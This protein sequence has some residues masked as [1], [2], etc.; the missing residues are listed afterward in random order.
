M[1]VRPKKLATRELVGKGDPQSPLDGGALLAAAQG[2]L[3]VLDADLLGRA[4]GSGAVRRALEA[5]HRAE[6]ERKRTGE[7]FEV[8]LRSFVGQVGAAWLLSCVFVRTLEDRGL[9][10]QARIA[11]PGALDSERQFFELAPSLTARDYL[12]AVFS[13]LGRFPAV[14]ELFDVRHNPVWLLAPSAEATRALLELFRA[15]HADGPAFRFGQDDTRFLGDLY[16]DLDEE[17]RSRFALLQTPR[18]VEAFI[19]DRTLEPAIERFGLDETTVID[20]TCGSGHFLLGAFERLLAH[21]LAREP[22]LDVREAARR[23]LEAVYGADINPYAVAI[24]R[25]RLT[26]AFLEKAGF[27]KLGQAPGL[28]LN[29]AVAD[30]L[31]HNWQREQRDLAD[32]AEAGAGWRDH[33]L[34]RLDDPAATKAV[35]GRT[36]AAVVGNPPYITPK[37]STLR[38]EYRRMYAE[39]AAGKYSLAAPFMQRFFQLGRPSASVG[40]IT[41]NSFMKREFGK[42]LIEGYLRMQN[43]DL[44]VNTSGAYIPGHGTP[45]VLVFGTSEAPKGREVQVV[46]ASR[47]EPETPEDAAEG[48]VWS[49]IRDHFA[50]VGFE[51]EYISVARVE[52]SSLEKH[53]WSL[54][55]GGAAELKELLEERAEKRLGD[56]AAEM[57]FA[58]FTGLDDIFI[59]PSHVARTRRFE[60]VVVRPMVV[61][62]S[63][64]DWSISTDEIAVTPYDKASHEPLALNPNAHWARFLWPFRTTA[65]NVASFGGKTREQEGQNWWEWYRWQAERYRAEFLLSFGEVATHN[66]FVLDRGGK[67]FNRTAP[68]IKLPEGATEEEHLALLAY[69]NSS[70]ACFWLKQACMNKGGSGIG[71]GIQD[72]AWEARF[73]FNTTKLAELPL[74]PG[75]TEDEQFRNFAR[76]LLQCAERLQDL[77]P[78]S[79]LERLAE[80]AELANV[81][82]EARRERQRIRDEQALAQ[83]HLDWEVYRRFGFDVKAY[84]AKMG[85]DGPGNRAFELVL[86]SDHPNTAWFSRNGHTP[87]GANEPLLESLRTHYREVAELEILECPEYKRRWMAEDLDSALR[88]A[89][90][91]LLGEHVE[92]LF[93]SEVQSTRSLEADLRATRAEAAVLL[94]CAGQSLRA[95][96]AD[97]AVPFASTHLFAGSGLEKRAL[98]QRTWDLQRRQDAGE[99]VGPIPVPP[100]YAQDDY[101]DPVFWRLRGKLDVPKERFISYPGCESDHDGEPVYGWAG[102]NHLQ[103]AQALSKLYQARKAEEGWG[104]ERLTPMLAGLLE[105]I[106][107]VKQWHNDPNEEYGGEKMGDALEQ[108]IDG[109]CR[110]LGLTHDDL[111]AWRPPE[112]GRKRRAATK[113]AEASEAAPAP[114]KARGRKKKAAAVEGGGDG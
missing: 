6:V 5:R 37:D 73:A 76:S 67:V 12:R 74:P 50:E 87:P 91:E 102:W 22:G 49:S 36:H 78:R 32:D 16:Q 84:F 39:S 79:L 86:A 90:A 77:S 81:L 9:L 80:G 42:R 108:F 30:S 11:G 27:S 66:H 46:L 25:F 43:L 64:R 24:A 31:L 3:K 44:I 23:A 114:K 34:Y 96:L 69:L 92:S 26:L 98:W 41:A 88:P 105:L 29:L 56:V 70:T 58:S 7:T 95:I 2:V 53:P 45:T 83:E 18:F 113:K 10:D 85:C 4:Q 99:D 28:R 94:E 60:E 13:E 106:P 89:A 51:N 111:R 103:R 38:D 54:G 71:R 110:S 82:K 100:K 15:P 75:V 20:P 1:G 40:M 33:D 19:L 63:I 72:E 55:G 62:E 52:R 21:R 57:G 107:W 59:L 101:R 61:G 8:W 93:R 47:G 14:R 112:K 35:L 65:N 97:T 48:K 68:I 17:V 104:A 109:E